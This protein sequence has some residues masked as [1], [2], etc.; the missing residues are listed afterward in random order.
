MRCAPASLPTASRR[1]STTPL[2]FPV[3]RRSVISDT[4]RAPTRTP[5]SWHRRCCRCR[6]IRN[7]RSRTSSVWPPPSAGISVG[8]VI[9][10]DP[11]QGQVLP[12]GPWLRVVRL[13]PRT[14]RRWAAFVRNHPDGL[15]YHHPNWLRVLIREYPADAIGLACE[16]MRGELRG[17]LPLVPTRG[18][19]LA[20]A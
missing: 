18:L 2:P 1:G 9:A 4:R 17:V 14:D 12:D 15:I 5:S 10:P 11:R 7:C 16:D 3:S 13:D 6:C 19:P 20:S 8:E